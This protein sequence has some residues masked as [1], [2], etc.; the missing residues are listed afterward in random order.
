MSQKDEMEL[1]PEFLEQ[2]ESIVK[3]ELFGRPGET[4]RQTLERFAKNFY[5]QIQDALE[6]NEYIYFSRVSREEKG[7]KTK[8]K[9]KD[10]EDL[11]FVSAGKNSRLKRKIQSD[12][13]FSE[14]DQ[15]Q[16]HQLSLF[17][18][19]EKEKE[20]SH[21]IELYDFIPK[22]V[23]GKV[24]RIAGVYLPRLEREFECRGRKYNLTLYPASIED[25]NGNEKYHYPSKREE[26]VEDVLRK[27]MAE[28]SGIFLDGEAAVQFTIYQLQKELKDSGHTYSRSQIKESLTI[29]TRT[30]IELKSESGN[31]EVLFSPIETLGFSGQ[32]EETNTF[33]RF[34]PLVTNSIKERTFRL[35]NY[36]KVMSY[37]SVI[38][39]Q[40]HKRMSHHYTQASLTETYTIL[41]TTII[42]DFGLTRRKQLKDN[43]RDVEQAIE[44]MIEQKVILK[45]SS[46]K[47]IEKS[48]R[49]KIVDVKLNFIPHPEFITEVK[50]ANSKQKGFD[51]IKELRTNR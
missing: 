32:N 7:T 6:K 4:R 24:E 36:E 45:Y 17:D 40:L 15:T 3:G 5:N 34:S 33:V 31:L 47:I 22:Y 29:L 49:F 41:L 39:R 27:I 16:P 46:E 14:F 42:R 18:L 28:G 35:F 1:T 44:E 30:D 38:A 21:T 9:T 25:A 37:R 20:F 19:L 43:L 51:K 23:W 2:V 48:P 13:K 50:F 26:I 10:T 11:T 12:K 8:R